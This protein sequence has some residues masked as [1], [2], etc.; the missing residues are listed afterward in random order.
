M[1]RGEAHRNA[2]TRVVKGLDDIAGE[3]LEAVDVAPWR[4][5][6]A[7]IGGE[8]VGGGGQGLQQLLGCGPGADSVVAS[9]ALAKIFGPEYGQRSGDGGDGP[10]M[11]PC[12]EEGDLIFQFRLQRTGRGCLVPSL[13]QRGNGLIEP[14][15][16]AVIRSGKQCVQ[17]EIPAVLKH[18]DGMEP[19]GGFAATFHIR[20]IVFLLEAAGTRRGPWP[21]VGVVEPAAGGVQEI[22]G[23]IDIQQALPFG[24]GICA[25][26]RF[27]PVEVN[28]AFGNEVAVEVG[29][30][31]A[32]I[33]KDGVVGR[34]GFEFHGLAEGFVVPGFGARE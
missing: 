4:I 6:L 19:P 7:E 5:P 18:P 13:E 9:N 11:I 34:I 2:R 23:L 20:G 12:A 31:A 10:A 32:G 28:V 21:V 29:D 25:I 14:G 22:G 15:Q 8:F 27:G 16:V 30:G 33:G 1:R 24:C 3:S 26:D 17:R